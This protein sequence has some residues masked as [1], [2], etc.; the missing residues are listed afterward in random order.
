LIKLSER[1]IEA[2]L[3]QQVKA[4]G[5]IAYK[6]NSPNRRNVPDRIC[7]FPNG[8]SIYVECKATGKT[9]TAGQQREIDRLK[10][11][12]QSATWVNTKEA[13]DI[14]VKEV[15]T[16]NYQQWI[17]NLYILLDRIEATEECNEEIKDLCRERFSLAK[18]QGIELKFGI[19]G[20]N[21]Q[22]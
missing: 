9:P 4:V 6:F 8:K 1:K 7:I 18:E 19:S 2:Y 21:T 16:S 17:M 22:H 3:C 15:P 5:G 11:L 13:V 20:S 10:D 12:E 14:L